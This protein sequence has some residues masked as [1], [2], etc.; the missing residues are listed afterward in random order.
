MRRRCYRLSATSSIALCNPNSLAKIRQKYR[1]IRQI[2]T[3]DL[4]FQL[5]P[6]YSVRDSERCGASP[7]A[8][9]PR[10]WYRG[11]MSEALP[12]VSGFAFAI[13]VAEKKVS[14]ATEARMVAELIISHEVVRRWLLS[15][16]MPDA[17]SQHGK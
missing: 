11:A 6:Y 10:S 9:G 8:F 4:P 1:E 14:A 2:R 5:N 13:D 3:P 16:A 12:E 7:C 15:C 17:L